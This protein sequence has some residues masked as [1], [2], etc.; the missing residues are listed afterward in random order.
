MDLK[1][2]KLDC[3]YNKEFSCQARGILIRQN[4]NCDTFK[5]NDN[6][7]EEQQ[8]NVSRTMFEVAPELHPYR[9]NKKVNIMCDATKCLFN[10]NGNCKSNGITVSRS[11]TKAYCSTAIREE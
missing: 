1:C 11:K 9:H 4:L 6:L 5:H 2:K 3:E 8:Q 10:D 7:T